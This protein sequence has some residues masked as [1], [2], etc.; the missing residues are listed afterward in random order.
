MS[1]EKVHKLCVG[2]AVFMVALFSAIASF[3]E[4]IHYGYDDMGQLTRAEYGDGRL[5]LGR[6]ARW[7]FTSQYP[8]VLCVGPCRRGLLEGLREI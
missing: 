2:S 8:A 7:K 4:T 1:R 6:E 5:V 3:A